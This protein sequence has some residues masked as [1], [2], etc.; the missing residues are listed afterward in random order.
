MARKSK[1]RII[2][3][4]RIT[5]TLA[6]GQREVLEAIAKQNSATLSFV[7]RYALKEFLERHEDKQL[8]FSF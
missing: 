6:E 1:T 3:S 2:S 5:I 7:V 8:R 4:D